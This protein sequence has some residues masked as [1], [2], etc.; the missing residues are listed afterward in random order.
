MGRTKTHANATARQAAFRE[1]QRDTRQALENLTTDVNDLLQA[2][3]VAAHAGDPLARQLGQ[4]G[5]NATLA[6]LTR[7]F[8]SARNSLLAEAQRATPAAPALAAPENHVRTASGTVSMPAVAPMSVDDDLRVFSYQRHEQR[9]RGLIHRPHGTGG[10][11][12]AFFTTPVALHVRGIEYQLPA[13]TCYIWEPGERQCFGNLREKWT[14]SWVSLD[15]LCLP[16]LLSRFHIPTGQPLS[17]ADASATE[18]FFQGV[19]EEFRSHLQPSAQVLY[20]LLEYWLLNISRGQFVPAIPPNWLAV[21]EYLDGHFTEQMTLA[22]LAEEFNQ[23]VSHFCHEFKRYFRTTIFDYLREK[24][25][26]QAAILLRDHNLSIGEVAHQVG[27]NDQRYFSLQFKACHHRSPRQMRNSLSGET[28]RKQWWA[29]TSTRELALLMREGWLPLVECDFSVTHALDPR[30]GV[31]TYYDDKGQRLCPT[32]E[33]AVFENDMLRILS[34]AGARWVEL[35][36]DEPLTEEVKLEVTIANPP[37]HGPDFA[38]AI[39]GDLRSGYRMRVFGY[40]YLAFETTANGEWTLLHLPSVAL[41]P[42][43]SCYRLSLWRADNVFY[44]EIDGQRILEYPEPFAFFGERHQTFAVGRMSGT[45][46]RTNILALRAFQRK[47]PRYV[48]ILEPGRVLLRQGH[49]AEAVAWFQRIAHEHNHPAQLQEI[50]YLLALA[51]PEA[52]KDEALQRVTADDANPFR[53]RALQQLAV[54]RCAREDMAGAVD[55]ARQVAELLPEDPT[56]WRVAHEICARLAPSSAITSKRLPCH[57]GTAARRFRDDQCSADRADVL[58]RHVAHRINHWRRRGDGSEPLHHMPLRILRCNCNHISDLTPLQGMPL[59][60]LELHNNRLTDI[61]PLAHLPL[62]GLHIA[63]NRISDLTPLAGL[64]LETLLCHGN[65]LRDLVPLHAT[66]LT[67]L[68][69]H[70]NQLRELAP[71]RHLPL[72]RCHCGANKLTSLA[73]LAHCPLQHLSCFDNPLA[74][75][76]PLCGLPLTQLDCRNC[77]ITSFSPLATLALTQLSC[78]GNPATDLTPLRGLPLTACDIGA[79][80]LTPANTAVLLRLPLHH[81][82]CTLADPSLA[83]LLAAHPTLTTINGHRL[84]HV[85]PMLAALRG[86]LLAFPQHPHTAPAPNLRLRRFAAP[87]AKSTC[88]PSPGSAPARKPTPSAAGNKAASSARTPR[89]STPHCRTTWPR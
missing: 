47:S 87:A 10:Y 13:L 15:G 88:W 35:C 4:P 12:L 28:L 37:P 1:R 68:H 5:A 6:A 78:A 16:A 44:A 69:C 48:D 77:R 80:P 72:A 63:N 24:R 83:P 41:A 9:A 23:S 52:R 25:M 11:L 8:L 14:Y 31:Y 2:I 39:S 22:R 40:H 46:Q 58:A 57:A 54:F 42:R 84:P 74:E 79:I 26:Q 7:R 67:G 82:C 50:A 32:P 36:W 20:L 49:A 19:Q 71:L 59:T 3:A 17:L 65:R 55:I 76:T 27:Y 66:T 60:D 81:L 56:P 51:A 61:S 73:P 33:L 86:A 45:D 53:L 70:H 89:S 34:D 62:R 43:A 18:V 30:F 29:E 21:R 64:P 38:L 75:L 85:A